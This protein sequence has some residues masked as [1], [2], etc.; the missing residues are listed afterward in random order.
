[1][2]D[3]KKTAKKTASKDTEIATRDEAALAPMELFESVPGEGFE[4][5]TADDLAIPFLKL[6]QKMSDEVDKDASAYVEGA[7]AGMFLD[8]AT[9]EL[10]EEVEFIACH[11][12]RAMVEWRDRDSGGGFIAQ[13]PVGHEA[14]FDR[15]TRG[16]K[17]TGRWRTGPE[18]HLVDTRYFFGLRLKSD[19]TVSPAV[20]SLSSTQIKKARTWVTKMRTLQG[21]NADGQKYQLPIF[22]GIWSLTSVHE[23]NDQGS[24]HGFKIEK[25]GIIEDAELARA[26]ADARG[27]FSSAAS[28]F[29]PVSEGGA[30]ESD[31]EDL[32]F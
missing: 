11:Y 32:P 28:Q 9:G 26:A 1:M 5:V 20:I 10:T 2:T 27:I 4:G 30:V 3:A 15:E 23:E 19:G 14:Q 8:T 31:N 18:T 13:H 25:I 6:L 16:D 22:A 29:P 24:W 7:E 17:W 12:H 21:E